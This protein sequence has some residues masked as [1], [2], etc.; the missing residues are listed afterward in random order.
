MASGSKVTKNGKTVIK[1]K[2][3][4]KKRRKTALQKM[5]DMAK[6]SR[7]TADTPF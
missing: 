5:V 3:A 6:R 4:A 7:R 2:T 1:R